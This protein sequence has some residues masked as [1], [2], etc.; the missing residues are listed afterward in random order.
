MPSWKP[1]WSGTGCE[2]EEIVWSE[3]GDEGEVET[4]PLAEEEEEESASSRGVENVLTQM[5]QRFGEWPL[6]T[7]EEEKALLAA[8]LISRKELPALAES[9][10]LTEEEVALGIRKRAQASMGLD[11]PPG[12][13]T[14]KDV[15][16][17]LRRAYQTVLEGEKARVR[18][19]LSNARLVVKLAKAH[20]AKWPGVPFEDLIQEGFSGL[21]K[22]IDRF[23]LRMNT[24]LSTYAS[25]WIRDALQKGVRR[26]LFAQRLA[27]AEGEETHLVPV[28]SIDDPINEEGDRFADFMAAPEVEAGEAGESEAQEAERAKLIAELLQELP[29]R[30]A[31]VLA[32]RYGLLGLQQEGYSELASRLGVTKTRVRQVEAKAL[33]LL[34]KIAQSRLGVAPDLQSLLGMPLGEVELEERDEEEEDE[35]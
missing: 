9:L 27:F 31:Y 25:W 34:A 6:L 20:A 19:I 4:L 1:S 22:A 17:A 5:F 3:G 30:E 26:H 11:A 8:Y 24:K 21:F 32:S 16:K 18:L 28:L 12:G 23:D 14:E 10:G 13:I 7:P 33:R 15:P 2:V 35:D 29:P